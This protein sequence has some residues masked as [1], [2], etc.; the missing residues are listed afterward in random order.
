MA[1]C[2]YSQWEGKCSMRDD[3]DTSHFGS[4]VVGWDENGYCVC[5]DDENPEGSCQYFEDIEHNF[6]EDED[7][8]T[9]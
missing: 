4:N 9:S 5:E 3:N 6:Y 1:Q 8:D 2:I 7:E